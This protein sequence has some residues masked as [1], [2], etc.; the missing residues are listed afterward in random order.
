MSLQKNDYDFLH[1]HTIILLKNQKHEQYGLML[2]NF[3]Y[4]YYFY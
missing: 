3:L 2:K 4:K 1:L